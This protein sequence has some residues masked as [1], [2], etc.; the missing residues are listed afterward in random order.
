M[1]K[2]I[3]CRLFCVHM[4]PNVPIKQAWVSTL[5]VEN[6]VYAS[7]QECS[8]VYILSEDLFSWIYF[9]RSNTSRGFPIHLSPSLKH[10]EI[11]IYLTNQHY[12]FKYQILSQT[13]NL[14][15]CSIFIYRIT[16]LQKGYSLSTLSAQMLS[17][18]WFF[19][20]PWTIAHQSP[21]SMGFFPQKSRSEVP[22]PPPGDLPNPKIEPVSLKSPISA[23]R[24]L[25]TVATWKAI[26]I[27]ST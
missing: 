6:T 19:G 14:F 7:H 17:C 11:S 2:K 4:I 9:Q 18:V 21:L 3:E 23:I 15:S 16:I 24:F 10:E 12:K 13:G 5:I 1:F 26:L 20:S 22:F 27:I 8:F 25:S